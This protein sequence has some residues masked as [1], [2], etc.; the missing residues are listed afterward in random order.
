MIYEHPV[1]PHYWYTSRVKLSFLTPPTSLIIVE[2]F[3]LP[4][5]GANLERSRRT[6]PLAGAPSLLWPVLHSVQ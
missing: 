6:C 3:S 5:S 1:F 4:L 2:R